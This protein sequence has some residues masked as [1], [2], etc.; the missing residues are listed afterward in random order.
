MEVP[1]KQGFE[2]EPFKVFPSI[3]AALRE[4]GVD[5]IRKQLAE[6]EAERR[7]LKVLLQAALAVERPRRRR[8]KKLA[9]EKNGT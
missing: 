8:S 5:D 6:I 2:Q 7:A 4:L 9:T 1:D 3:A